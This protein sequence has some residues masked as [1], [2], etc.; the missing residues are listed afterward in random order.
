[1]LDFLCENQ[2]W[3]KRLASTRA[4]VS[5]E[6]LSH[7]RQERTNLS[8][9]LHHCQLSASPS[10][11]YEFDDDFT[12][13]YVHDRQSTTK[14]QSL[15]DNLEEQ[16]LLYTQYY[17]ISD[18]LKHPLLWISLELAS[19]VQFLDQSFSRPRV[20]LIILHVL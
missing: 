20:C 13:L 11:V 5:D 2:E 19:R 18:G 1:M 3:A 8:R 7:P 17:W 9:C 6:F 10:L 15:T 14:C 12:V 16:S 4:A